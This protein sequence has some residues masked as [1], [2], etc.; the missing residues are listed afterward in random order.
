MIVCKVKNNPNIV[1]RDVSSIE[2]ATG[3]NQGL[4]SNHEVFIFESEDKKIEY[5]PRNLDKIFPN[6]KGIF[7]ENGRLKEL[8][9]SDFR[10]YSAIL[11][12]ELNNHDIQVL[13]EGVFDFLSA[14]KSIWMSNNKIIHIDENVFENLENL[15]TL[16][17]V[18]NQCAN[19]RDK[20][21]KNYS[22]NIRDIFKNQ[23]FDQNYSQLSTKLKNIEDEAKN[24]KNDNFYMFGLDLE[25]LEKEFKNSKFS[26]LTSFKERF[27]MLKFITPQSVASQSACLVS[28]F[29]NLEAGLKASVSTILDKKIRNFKDESCEL[30]D[31]RISGNNNA[32]ENSLSDMTNTLRNTERKI[33]KMNNKW[34]ELVQFPTV[35]SKRMSQFESDQKL[36][37]KREVHGLKA[38]NDA[39]NKKFKNLEERIGKIEE[40][41][42]KLLA[43]HNLS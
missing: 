16:T 12:L 6:L 25:K 5:F 24:L 42:Q 7:I 27:H 10:G 29:D 11:Y 18:Q 19:I 9:R 38:K 14:I 21:Y 43:A 31:V 30:I 1:S 17:L 4:N 32:L 3:N 15:V 40:N 35:M 23:C 33:E 22:K 26:Y 34:D 20:I 39:D 41:I 28:Q 8:H 36:F 2:S 13:E 37:T